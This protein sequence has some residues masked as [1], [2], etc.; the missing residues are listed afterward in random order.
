MKV[1]YVVSSSNEIDGSSKSFINMINGTTAAGVDA[2][3]IL[4]DTKDMYQTLSKAGIKVFATNYRFSVIPSFKSTR[5]KIRFL[6]RLLKRYILNG[7]SQGKI[8]KVIRDFNPDIIHTNV[9]PIDVGFKGALR[10]HTPH[11]YHIREYGDKDFKLKICNIDYNLRNSYTISIT[12]DIAEHRNLLN[13]DKDTVIYNGI[14]SESAIRFTEKKEP[15]FLYA[16]R[17]TELKGFGLLIDAYIDYAKKTENPLRLKVAGA[18]ELSVECEK[19]VADIKNKLEQENVSGLVDWLGVVKSISDLAYKAAATV[20]P[21]F[22]EGFGRVVAEAMF[23]GSLVIGF[24]AGG[25]KE[26]FDN[27]LNKFGEEIALRFDDRQSLTLQL[28]NVTSNL[29][30]YFP[31]IHRSQ[32]CVKE[33]YSTES[34]VNSVIN[35]YKFITNKTVCNG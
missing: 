1:L 31:L 24:N 6:P 7:R 12:R 13:P 8:N 17:L 3:V 20:V 5:D 32:V 2:L 15:Y 30:S 18:P 34:N 10:H 14:F 29:N 4:P 35:F 27:G 19:F 28:E 9:S 33:L 26:Q 21:S 16:G 11:V 23:N 25:I 22:C